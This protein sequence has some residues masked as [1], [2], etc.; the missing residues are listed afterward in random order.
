MNV[1]T[2]LFLL[3]GVGWLEEQNGL[4]GQKNAGRVKELVR[5]KSQK[6]TYEW[7]MGKNED[8]SLQDERKRAIRCGERRWPKL[9]QQASRH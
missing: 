2:L 8:R 4:G 7:R 5:L 9:S 1:G 6:A 3:W